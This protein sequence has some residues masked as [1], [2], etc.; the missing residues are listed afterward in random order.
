MATQQQRDFC[1]AIYRAAEKLNEI[2]PVFVAAQACLE[3][4]W[5]EHKIGKYNVFGITRGS[6]WPINRCILVTTREVF[7]T[8]NVRFTSPEEVI[9]IKRKAVGKY[10]Y[11]VKRLFKDFN[12]YEEC[13]QEHLRIYKKSGYADAWT[14]RKD[15]REFARRISD[16][17]GWRYATDPNYYKTMCS[18]ISSV[19]K[20]IRA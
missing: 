20:I 7:K 1:K 8:A 14:Y 18:M 15:A 5:G 10:E 13:L 3:S 12:S 19:E 9:S 16:T 4:G 2:S 17:T 11:K 6:N